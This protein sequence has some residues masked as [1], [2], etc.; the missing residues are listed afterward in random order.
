M[1]KLLGL[2]GKYFHTFDEQGVVKDQGSI[3]SENDGYV[4]VEFIDW[5]TGL[6]SAERMVPKRDLVKWQLYPDE[7]AMNEYRRQARYRKQDDW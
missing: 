2:T 1:G 4:V 6:V 5:D 7:E 3:I